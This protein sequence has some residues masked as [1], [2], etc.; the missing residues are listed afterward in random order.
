MQYPGRR[1]ATTDQDAVQGHP[2]S[3]A[4]LEE[5]APLRIDRRALTIDEDHEVG[6]GGFG[7][8]MRAQL[9][10]LSSRSRP[11]EVAVKRSYVS[12][13]EGDNARIMIVRRIFN[14]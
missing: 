14:T 6:R 8:V 12:I 11:M 7:V 2:M 9:R 3:Q 1:P 13:E 4:V 10:V 5:L